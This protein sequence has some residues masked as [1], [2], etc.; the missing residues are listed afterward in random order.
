[1]SASFAHLIDFQ[2]GTSAH[3][4]HTQVWDRPSTNTH[5][6]TLLSSVKITVTSSQEIFTVDCPCA[7]FISGAAVPSFCSAFPSL[8][9]LCHSPFTS[10]SVLSSLAQGPSFFLNHSIFNLVMSWS[11]IKIPMVIWI[12]K[13]DSVV[14][15]CHL[16]HV[17][18]L[19]V[20]I[21]I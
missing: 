3:H 8:G 10:A 6:A 13:I 2:P 12:I 19:L 17:L 16:V 1:M 5:A 14:L 9:L 18:Q 20:A 11:L 15:Y 7:G 21:C 4:S